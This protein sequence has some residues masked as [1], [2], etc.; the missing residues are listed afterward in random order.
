MSAIDPFDAFVDTVKE[1]T[2]TFWVEFA[3]VLTT[4]VERSPSW[5]RTG[6]LLAE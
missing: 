2:V 4:S 1:L 6:S 5:K 3:R